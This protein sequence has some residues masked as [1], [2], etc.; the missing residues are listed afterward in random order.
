MRHG[1]SRVMAW[2]TWWAMIQMHA[3]LYKKMWK[4]LMFLLFTSQSCTAM[5][6]FDK[7]PKKNN[8]EVCGCITATYQR[9]QR[10]RTHQGTVMSDWGHAL[11][12]LLP[13]SYLLPTTVKHN[14]DTCAK[15]P[16]KHSSTSK[17]DTRASWYVLF[18]VGVFLG[19]LLQPCPSF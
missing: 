3:V 13:S 9:H 19:K 11:S 14:Y 15:A 7:I 18:T 5:R 6:L 16:C 8:I 17:D 2:G 1:G 4:I 12:F 10:V